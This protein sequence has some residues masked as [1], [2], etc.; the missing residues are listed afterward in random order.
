MKTLIVSLILLF[1]CVCPVRAEQ[2]CIAADEAFRVVYGNGILTT[3]EVASNGRT[4]LAEALGSSHNGQEIEFDLAYN[5]T[6]GP[7]SDLLQALDQ[8]LAQ[9]TRETL[10]WLHGIGAVPDWFL[11]MQERL[12]LAHYQANAPELTDHVQ[13]YRE[14]ILQGRK[15]L[16]VSHSQGNFYANQARQI[17]ASVQPQVPMDSFGIFSVATPA[18]Q[19]GGAGGPYLTNHRDIILMVPGS[20]AQNWLLTHRDDGRV[21]DEYSRI[22]AHGFIETYLASAFDARAALLAGI[23]QRLDQLQDPPQVAGSGPVTATLVWDLDQSDLDLHVFEPDGRHLDYR[24]PEGSS[25]MIDVDSVSGF[26]PEHYYTD[27]NQLQTG[28]YVFAINYY[29][30]HQAERAPG[31][32]RTVTATLT[33]SVPGASRSFEVVLDRHRGTTGDDAPH[34]VGRVSVE[35]ISDPD[36]PNR[37]G[38][39]LY[40]ISAS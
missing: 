31:P 36:N 22:Q 8:H 30:D 24:N 21:A 25:G 18:D 40:E 11:A 33:L 20:L 5:H 12:L 10:Q 4:Q 14:A 7:F 19:V 38:L 37:D 27:C 16:V 1:F 29:G 23:R 39:L 15:V 35:R 3:Q 28:D 9:Y 6:E 13:K 2:S 17:L 32:A 26:G 34:Q